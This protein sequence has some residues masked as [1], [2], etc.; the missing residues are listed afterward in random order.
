MIGARIYLRKVQVGDLEGGYVRW[1]NDPDVTQFTESRFCSHSKEELRRYILRHTTGM[2]NLLL[3]IV[4]REGD[5]H[6][7]N[8]KLGPINWIHRCS[9]V[10]IIIGEKSCWS[11]GYGV[12]A[13][14]VL[15]EWAFRCLELHKLTAGCYAPNIASIKAFQRSGF[16]IEGVRKEQYLWNGKY[17]DLVLLGRLST[18]TENL[19]EEQAG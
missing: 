8:I 17:E 15:A 11:M 18:K 2:D 9:E 13:I 19:H 16:V 7:G 3:A 1:M 6:I 4:L 14:S 10:G 12:E 5:R